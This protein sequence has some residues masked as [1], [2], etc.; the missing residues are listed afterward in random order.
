MFLL[1]F[2][3]WIILNGKITLEIC[4]IGAAITAAIY[5]FACKFLG[6]GLKSDIKI[7]K[8]LLWGIAYAGALALEI[9]K[10]NFNVLKVVLNGKRH[11]DPSIV[12]VDFDLKDE[13]SLVILANSITLTPGTITVSVEGN[14]LC[15][16][17]LCSE[18]SDGIENC[19]F[20]RLLKKMEAASGKY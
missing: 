8:N 2:A 9:L 10:A 5:A 16:H 18:Y 20:V 11:T 6:Y 12:Y 19:I 4:V 14:R 1:L 3:V 13:K 7:L 17:C 15:I